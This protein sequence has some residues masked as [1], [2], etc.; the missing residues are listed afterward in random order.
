MAVELATA[1]VSLVPSFRGAKA[2]IASELSVDGPAEQAGQSAGRRFTGALGRV[3]KGTVVGIGVAAGAA[4]GTALTKGWQRLI[5]IETATSQLQGL[6]HSAETIETIMGNALASVRGTA[7]GL[8]EAATVAASA[9]AANIKPGE[10]LER[11][12]KLVADTSTIAGA[13]LSEVG[14]IF[15]KVAANTK[16]TMAEVGQLGDR[17]VPVLSMLAD[18]L[19]VTAAEAAKM[20][21][22]GKVD[23][24][25][26]AAAIEN[27]IAGAALRSGETTLGAFANMGAAAGRFGA[28]LLEGVFPL[29]KE[30]FGGITRYIDMATDA[31]RPFAAQFTEFVMDKV[32]PAGERLLKMASDIAAGFREFFASDEGQALRTETFDRLSSIFASLSEAGQRLGPAFATIAGSIGKAVAAVGISTW[33]LLLTTVDALAQVAVAVLVPAIEAL[34][35]WMS[36]NQRTVTALVGAYVAYRTAMVAVTAAKGAALAVM[37]TYR[38]VTLAITAAS[39]GAAGATY[40]QGTAL[41]LYT[42]MSR[43][44][45]AATKIWAGVQWALNAALSANPIGLIVAAIAALVAGIV[46]AY[47]RSETFRNIVDGALRAVGNAAKW[48]WENAIKPAWDG[49]VAAFQFVAG[50]IS[51]WW[52]NVTSPI[53]NTVMQIVTSLANLFKWAFNIVVG[54][55]ITGAQVAIQALGEAVSWLWENAFKPAFERIGATATWLWENA[56]QPAFTAVANAAKW[57]WQKGIK[58]AFDGVRNVISSAWSNVIKPTFDKIM[59]I[60]GKV[61]DTFRKA[62]SAIGG[63][64]R[65]AF[66][67]ATRTMKSAINGIIRLINNVV[68]GINNNVIAHANRIPGVNFPRIPTIP[69]LAEGGIVLPTAGGRIVRVAEAGQAEAV[70]PLDKLERMIGTG[71]G[72]QVYINA[73]GLDRALAEW[74]RRAVRV[75]GGGNVQRFAGL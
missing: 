7:F 24:E 58:P 55:M 31:V 10:D 72:A 70:I 74:F 11:V 45:A 44:T 32:L 34:A 49:I 41:K 37:G 46:I 2:Q 51:W 13:S 4:L 22:A 9:V 67:T 15:N 16:L 43:T 25:T 18:Q 47:K 23:F 54:P 59:S 60:V 53:F 35:R 21:S 29:A 36:D 3:V 68:T 71:G 12:L 66:D 39:Y 28:V 17:G 40:A 14:S 1:Y 57:L 69:S 48:L 50:V 61:R 8:G 73:A 64:I 20:V 38:A 19:G 5:A 65:N 52:N 26:F 30:V 42:V 6:Q 62:F 27:N 75:Q 33:K 56:I 63:F